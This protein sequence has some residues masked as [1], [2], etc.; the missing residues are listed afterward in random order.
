MSEQ[1]LGTSKCRFEHWASSVCSV[2]TT[3]VV[4]AAAT[5]THCRWCLAR[6]RLPIVYCKYLSVLGCLSLL[7]LALG[8]AAECQV[9]GLLTRFVFIH[10]S[11]YGFPVHHLHTRESESVDCKVVLG[12]SVRDTYLDWSNSSRPSANIGSLVKFCKYTPL[13]LM[14]V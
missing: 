7:V 1:A 10:Q 9:V 5:T 12:A 14:R 3:V 11:L 13:D 4:V 8:L 2:T 6:G